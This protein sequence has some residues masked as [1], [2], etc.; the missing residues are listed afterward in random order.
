[1][2]KSFACMRM[3][4]N[5]R[6]IDVTRRGDLLSAAHLISYLRGGAFSPR[7]IAV[8]GQNVREVV[9]TVRS[10][11]RV[12]SSRCVAWT[13]THFPLHRHQMPPQLPLL[14]NLLMRRNFRDRECRLDPLLVCLSVWF[15]RRSEI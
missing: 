8:L 6:G 9:R 10:T 1:M 14:R 5:L 15:G 13:S 3:R 7:T 12:A 2:A 11:Q 4:R